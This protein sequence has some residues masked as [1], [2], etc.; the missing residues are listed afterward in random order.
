MVSTRSLALALLLTPVSVL[1]QAAPASAPEVVEARLH[2]A[3]VSVAAAHEP[4]EIPAEID[5]PQLV[6]RAVLL[7]RVG[8]EPD[9]REIELAR[10]SAG[11]YVAIVPAEHVRWPSLEYAVEL[12]LTSGQRVA[13][14]ASRAAPHRV[15]V[16]EDLADVRERVL[17]ERL[18]GRRSV[19]AASA[20]Y[21]SF[22]SSRTVDAVSGQPTT[23]D[24][25]YYRVEGSYTYRPMRLV[26][27]FGVR[28][29]SLRGK[30]PV[31][32][33][34]LAPGQ[35]RDEQFDVG[36]DYGAPRVRFRASDVVHLDCELVVGF[37]EVGFS[38]G[39]GGALLIGDPYGERLTLGFESLQDFGARMYSRVDLRAAEGLRVAPI[40]EVTNMPSA[41]K[42]GVR[43]LGEISLEL[44]SGF[45]VAV[46]GGYQARVSTSGGPS[47][48]AL[49][50]YAF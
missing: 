24:D 14:F 6:R 30:A 26:M 17:Y 4:L 45:G 46:R 20:E 39:G 10:A 16:P 33:R 7:Y 8:A 9:L 38:W 19:F 34:E 23:V 11:P 25:R 44:G 36:L 18:G 48:G 3:P 28:G 21:V 5:H 47:G 27:E 22:G 29:G 49:V 15:Q 40:I 35:S 43:L 42:Y 13:V 12:E 50:S 31:P 37:T 41:E 2:H 32:V 1:A